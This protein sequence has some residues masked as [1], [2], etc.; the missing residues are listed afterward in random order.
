MQIK[1]KIHHIRETQV[2]LDKDLA[3][4]YE[5]ETRTLNQAV[6]RNRIKFPQDFMFQLT[7]KEVELMVSQF[8]IPSKS[9]LGGYSP[10]AFTEQGVAMLSGILKSKKA[11]E[12]NIYIMRAFIAMRKSITANS[13]MILKINHIDSKIIEHDN[14]FEKVFRAIEQKQITPDKGIFYDGQV[15]DAYKFIADIIRSANKSITLID[16][17]IDDTVLTLLQKRKEGVK[18]TIFTKEISKQ[19]ALDIEKYN[20]QNE[21]IEIK[22]FAKAHDRFIVIDQTTTYHLGASLKDAGK[23]WFAF[24]KFDSQGLEIIKKLESD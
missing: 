2:I 17:Y 10:F 16:N 13:Q 12:V 3:K 22:E 9:N 6:K 5:V 20:T 11:I 7:K 23:K 19:L 24:S 18:V 1:D 4:L 21:P 8:V 14:N 15:F